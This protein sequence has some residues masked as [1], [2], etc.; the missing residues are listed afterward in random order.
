MQESF[1]RLPNQKSINVFG[2]IND[3]FLFLNGAVSLFPIFSSYRHFRE[4]GNFVL[5]VQFSFPL[6]GFCC[7]RKREESNGVIIMN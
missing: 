5:I 7:T 1:F 2:L 6:I 3:T 4:A